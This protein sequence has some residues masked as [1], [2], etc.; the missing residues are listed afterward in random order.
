[1]FS[2]AHKKGKKCSRDRVNIGKYS[3]TG[4]SL[5]PHLPIN[6]PAMVRFI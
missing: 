3:N 4:L 2:L 6:V 5:A 1:M